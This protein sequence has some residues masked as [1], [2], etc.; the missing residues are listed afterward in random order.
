MIALDGDG[1]E[2]PW[3]HLIPGMMNHYYHADNSVPTTI[4]KC[5]AWKYT[6]VMTIKAT[7]EYKENTT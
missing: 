4:W 2:P 5:E 1:M 7:H 3:T 6:N